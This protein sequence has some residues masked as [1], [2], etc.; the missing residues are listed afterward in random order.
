MCI[1]YFY[2]K[3]PESFF[4]IK[5]RNQYAI[6]LQLLDS[7]SLQP[8]PK[9]RA[10]Q[11]LVLESPLL[12]VR[13][14]LLVQAVDFLQSS[15]RVRYGRVKVLVLQRLEQAGLLELVQDALL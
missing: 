8:L 13:C 12:Q 10:F 7:Q 14:V 5:F 3:F 15:I 2:F 6:I 1:V 4:Q 11:Q 9:L